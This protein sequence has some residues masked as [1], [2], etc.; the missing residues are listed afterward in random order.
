MASKLARLLSDSRRALLTMLG[1]QAVIWSVQVVNWLDDYDLSK[2]FGLRPERVDDLPEMF[3]MPFLHFSWDHIVA[4]S[5]PLFVLGF[6]AAYRGMRKFLL[7]SLVITVS[8]G[9]TVWLLESP[10]TVTAGASG[11]VYGYLGYVVLRGVLDRN[12]LDAVV[13]IGVAAVYWTIL[14]GVL[15]VVH[16]VSWLGHLGGLIGGLA[17]AV[18]LRNQAKPKPVPVATDPNSPNAALLKELDDLGL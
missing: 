16:G 7:A 4:N 11:M 10:N 14:I 6:L 18:L 17:A 13:G 1:I 12:V 15:P 8:G 5:W 3:T 2:E 9:L